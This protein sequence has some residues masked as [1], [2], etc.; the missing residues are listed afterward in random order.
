MSGLSIGR[1]VPID[2]DNSLGFLVSDIARALRERF[3]DTA[4]AVGLT[5][6]QAR[7]LLHLANLEGIS[8]VAL[9]RRLEIQP[10]TMLRQID[11]LEE[12]GLIERRPNP[13]D[14]R[15]QQLYLTPAADPLL[16]EISRLGGSLTEAAFA[17]MSDEERQRIIELLQ[18]GKLNLA[19]VLPSTSAQP[20]VK[21]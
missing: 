6:A 11:R 16:S 12:A 3:N 8:Q 19:T 21:G 9:A 5:L 18:Q 10:I 14:R 1:S 15:A 7:A 17:G 2:P 13:R 20:S 4:Q